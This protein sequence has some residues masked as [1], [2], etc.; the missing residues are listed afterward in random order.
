MP[1]KDDIFVDIRI[2]G[3]SVEWFSWPELGRWRECHVGQ[4]GVDNEQTKR[5]GKGMEYGSREG[6]L[7][8][9]GPTPPLRLFSSSKHFPESE[10]EALRANSRNI[11]ALQVISPSPA[12]WSF[13]AATHRGLQC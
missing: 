13:G 11:G 5:A 1:Y 3:T 12:L 7:G 4:V 9:S 8:R 10:L 6:K 2:N